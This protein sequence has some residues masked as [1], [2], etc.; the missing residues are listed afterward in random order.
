MNLK[1]CEHHDYIYY[2]L[3]NEIHRPNGPA[4]IWHPLR[5]GNAYWYLFGKPH[6]Y[7]GFWAV[8]PEFQHPQTIWRIHGEDLYLT[9]R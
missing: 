8:G 7:Y 4:Y 6:R 2:E 3:N 1:I 9:P 5:G